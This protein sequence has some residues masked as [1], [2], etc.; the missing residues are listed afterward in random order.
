MEKGHFT[1]ILLDEG[2]QSR[3]PESI[4]PLCLADIDTKIIIV[5]DH[6]QV[7]Y[8]CIYIA[9]Y[10]MLYY[11]ALQ[12]GPSILVLGDVAREYGLKYSV[13]ERLHERYTSE[14]YECSELHR[15]TLLTN[16][17]CHH[18]LLSLSSYLFYES[19]LLT[20]AVASTFTHPRAGSLSFICSSLD[21]KVKMVKKSSNKLEV[22]L[23]LDEVLKYIKN[24]PPECSIE[25]ICVMAATENQVCTC[26]CIQD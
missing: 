15:M 26:T 18:A 13:L 7:Y 16:Y 6:K 3:E 21:N 24:M 10:I 23:I 4:A 25:D 9:Q 8:T 11:T 17:R 20:K 19:A 1:H 12:V 2:A 22:T 14:L 5:G